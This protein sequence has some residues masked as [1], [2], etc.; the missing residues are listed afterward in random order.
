MHA[1]FRRTRVAVLCVLL[2]SFVGACSTAEP[3]PA[4]PAASATGTPTPTPTPDVPPDGRDL[5]VDELVVPAAAP[6]MP[7]A[8]REKFVIGYGPG[9]KLLGTAPGGDSGWLDLGP[10]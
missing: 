5:D 6:A 8:W 3:E 2:A 1:D 9:M 7:A 4:P 10:E